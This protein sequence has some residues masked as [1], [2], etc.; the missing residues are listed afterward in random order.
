M[1]KIKLT[2]R[3]K[4]AVKISLTVLQ[5]LIIVLTV[6]ISVFTIVSSNSGELASGVTGTSFLPVLTD[7]MS[8][9]IEEGDLIIAKTPDDKNALKTGD[10]IT[11]SAVI[12]GQNAINTHRIIEIKT[13]EI[14]D[15][16][17]YV[18]H[19][20][21]APEGVNE[22]VY[23]SSVLAVYGGK[24]ENLGGVILWLQKPAHF[25][26]VIMIPLILLFLYNGYVFAK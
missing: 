13:N 26:I 6:S 2:D 15:Q 20:D 21:N 24:I 25:F 11:F 14:G 8:P 9:Y 10:I 22:E 18:T 3:Q 17:V 23:A 12:N 7:S 4:K 19:G 5:I 1:K 16:T